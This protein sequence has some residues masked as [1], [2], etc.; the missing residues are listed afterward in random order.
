[1]GIAGDARPVTVAEGLNRRRG[2]HA[3]G[4]TSRKTGADGLVWSI[5]G[6]PLPL[7]FAQFSAHDSADCIGQRR[8]VANPESH[9]CVGAT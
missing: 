1:M 2:C 6:D 7:L 9:G 8:C 3:D 5:A 4:V